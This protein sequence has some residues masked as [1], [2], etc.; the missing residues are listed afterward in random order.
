MYI[1]QPHG[2][3]VSRPLLVI[4]LQLLSIRNVHAQ[5]SS[6]GGSTCYDSKGDAVACPVRK[7]A[8]IAGV[9]IGASKIY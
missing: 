1:S 8:V 4:L 3:G 6:G 7:K 9:V 5:G 2:M